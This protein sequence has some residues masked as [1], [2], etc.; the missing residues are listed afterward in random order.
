[1]RT[2]VTIDD[3]LLANAQAYSG[4]TEVGPLVREALTKLV[5]REAARR[6]AAMG[7]TQKDVVFDVPRRRFPAADDDSE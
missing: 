5:Q 7:G 6:L 2:T 4:I 1:M 3:K